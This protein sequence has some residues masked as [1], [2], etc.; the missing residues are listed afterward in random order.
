[1]KI[2]KQIYYSLPLIVVAS[3]TSFANSSYDCTQYKFGKFYIYNKASRQRIDIVRKDSL[4]I[5]TNVE[6]GD[7]TVMRVNW[8]GECEYELLFNYTTPKEVAKSTRSQTAV[9]VAA[10]IP[11][12]IRIL[13]GTE[14]YYVFEARKQGLKPLRDTVWLIKENASAF[15]N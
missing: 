4:Q 3:L 8:T 7:I 12:Q 15:T 10:H 11:V 9:E 5:E 13:T 14:N 6:S 2:R 1:M